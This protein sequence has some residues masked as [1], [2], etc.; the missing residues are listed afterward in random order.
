MRKT[1]AYT[2]WLTLAASEARKQKP[3]AINGPYHLSLRMVRPD[4]RRRDL[5]NLIKPTSDL[6]VC[7]GVIEDDCHCEMLTARWVTAGEGLYV[8]VQP[9]GVE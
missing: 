2:A 7:I 6:L 5:D 9:A 1:D 4:K 3:A 8:R